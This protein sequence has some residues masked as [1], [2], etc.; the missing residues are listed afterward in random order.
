[1]V[2][3]R[4]RGFSPEEG[5][6]LWRRWKAGESLVEIS[7]ALGRKAGAVYAK[8]RTAGGIGPAIKVRAARSLHLVDREEISRGLASG[9]S[10]GRI[11]RG[12]GRSVSTISREVARNKGRTLYR[13]SQ[14]D[15]LCWQRAARPKECVLTTRPAL[16]RV[17][18]EKLQVLWAPQQI[19]CWLKTE[20]RDDRTMQ[21]SHE[22]IY[23]SLFIQARGVLKK[24]LLA[25]LR[26]R[27]LMRRGRPATQK[28]ELRGQIVDAVSIRD[29]PAEVEDRAVPG[30]WEGD[31]VSGKG[32]THIVTLVERHSRYVVLAKL[33]SRQSEDVVTALIAQVRRLP[34]GLMASLTWDRGKEMAQHKRFSIAT[35]VAVYFCDPHSPWQRGSNENTNGLLRQYFPKGTD[36]AVHS[37][38]YLDKVADQM[39]TR[40]RMTLA[41]QTPAAILAKAIAATG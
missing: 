40:P 10:F 26:S 39:N 5:R 11:A 16:A 13:A 23:K 27:R 34:A 18:A 31:L 37:Q 25:G 29:R 32:N 8:L 36:L 20:Y 12:L 6:E 4:R 35:D 17:V 28:R 24:E 30:H 3:G 21:V 22:T 14:A 1:M 2:E 38:T 15:A 41:Y 9:H 7:R 19:A 33:E